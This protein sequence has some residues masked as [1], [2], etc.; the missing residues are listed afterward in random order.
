M[1]P[2]QRTR[3]KRS[4]AVA[5]WGWE[6]GIRRK[7]TRNKKGCLGQYGTVGLELGGVDSSVRDSHGW[8]ALFWTERLFA[9]REVT[10]DEEW[11]GNRPLRTSQ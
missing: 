8:A 1:I 7:A 3:E 5:D 11:S 2:G 9:W 4:V 6:Q 10:M